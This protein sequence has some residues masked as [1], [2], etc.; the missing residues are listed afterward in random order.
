MSISEANVIWN[1]RF[2]IPGVW[3]NAGA[4]IFQSNNWF[5]PSSDIMHM[6]MLKKFSTKE[7]HFEHPHDVTSLGRICVPAFAQT[8]GIANLLFQITLSE[9]NRKATNQAVR[10]WVEVQ[11]AHILE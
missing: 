10:P 8:P 3:A 4:Q 1:R 6:N 7:L 5:Y 9:A 11:K 2:A